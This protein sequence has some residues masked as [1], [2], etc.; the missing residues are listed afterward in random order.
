MIHIVT[1][2]WQSD[3][4][5]D[6]QLYY[7]QKFVPQPFKVYAFLNGIDKH[8]YEKFFYVCDEPIEEHAIKLNLLSHIVAQQAKNED[9]LIFLD[10]DAFPVATF[11]DFLQNTLPTYPL[12]AIVR[13]E[14]LQDQQPHPSFCITTV[15]FWKQLE[16]DWKRGYCWIDSSGQLISDVGG[17]LLKQL[18]DSNTNWLQL[19]RTHSLSSHPVA[20][21]IY[22]DLVYHHG[23]GF[24]PPAERIDINDKT[25]KTRFF[26]WAASKSRS[27]NA[28]LDTS[29]QKAIEQEISV[30][31][32]DMHQTIYDKIKNNRDSIFRSLE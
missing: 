25:I 11:Q 1:V 20:H 21:G 2:H 4:W 12:A 26:W 28:I 8:H 6:L 10:G 23:S 27:L 15:G 14:N 18:R 32:N 30:H 5:I 31:Q 13:K 17:N 22:H 29:L 16:G 24:R 3:Q 7:L 19:Y 9:V